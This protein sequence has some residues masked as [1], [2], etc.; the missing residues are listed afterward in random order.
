MLQGTADLEQAAAADLDNY[1]RHFSKLP[2][3][4]EGLVTRQ[5]VE[6]HMSE[7]LQVRRIVGAPPCLWLSRPQHLT[8]Q[9]RLP[10]PDQA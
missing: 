1:A 8:A 10:A 6:D 4:Q 3:S 9:Q 2:G 5:A 7:L